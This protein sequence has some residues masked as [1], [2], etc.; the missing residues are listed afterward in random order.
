ML[1]SAIL[2]PFVP[3]VIQENQETAQITNSSYE[4]LTMQQRVAPQN[5]QPGP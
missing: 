1:S 3:A 2:R 5:Y 4:R